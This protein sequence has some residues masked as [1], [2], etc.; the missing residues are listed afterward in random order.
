MPMCDTDPPARPDAG[1]SC[2]PIHD[3]RPPELPN[4]GDCSVNP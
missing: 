1:L 4:V 3:R 2:F